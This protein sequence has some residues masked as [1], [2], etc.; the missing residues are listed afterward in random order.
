MVNNISYV[1][2]VLTLPN[3]SVKFPFNI[4]SMLVYNG[5]FVVLLDIPNEDAICSKSLPRNNTI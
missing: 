2:N 5:V 3:K 4:D 1:D